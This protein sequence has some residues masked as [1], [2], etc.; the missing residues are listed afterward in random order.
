MRNLKT[1]TVAAL[2]FLALLFVVSATPAKAQAHPHYLQAI[3]DLRSA[4]WYLSNDHRPDLVDARNH[5]YTEIDEAIAEMKK[6]A[7]RE[8]KD[9]WATPPPQSGG[10]P[11]AAFHAAM[12]LLREARTDVEGGEDLPENAGLRLR[13]EKHINEALRHLNPYI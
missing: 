9:V 6:A 1:V 12:K 10:D 13:S 4:R 5:A 7:S 3:S 2:A 11:R 8:G